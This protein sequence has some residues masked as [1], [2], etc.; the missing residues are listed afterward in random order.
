M[1]AITT[2]MRRAM[3]VHANIRKLVPIAR[4]SASAKKTNVVCVA[5]KVQ[6][7]T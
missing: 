3:M 1:H 5:A 2:K 4:A 6:V 7:L